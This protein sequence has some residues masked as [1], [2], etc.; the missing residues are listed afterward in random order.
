MFELSEHSVSVTFVCLCVCYILYWVLQLLVTDVSADLLCVFVRLFILYWVLQLLFTDI[1]ADLLCVFVRL[2][3]PI[4]SATVALHRRIRWFTAC[5]CAFVITYIE[6]YSCSSQTCP[7]IYCVCLCVCYILYWVL[8]LLFTD[9]SGD[10]LCVLMRLLYPILSVTVALH[11][12]IWW[13]TACV[14]A[15]VISY[16]ECYSCSSQ[17]YPVIYCVCLCVCYILYWVLQ[18]LFTDVSGDLL[19][20]FVRL[21]LPILSVTVALHRRIWWFTACVCAF[22]MSYIECYS[23]SSQTYPV[24][25]CVCLCVCYILYWVLQLLFTDVSGDLLRVFVR[26]LY[27]ILSVTVALHRRIRWFTACVC[28]FAISYIECYSCSLQ[29]YPVIYCV[30]APCVISYIECYSCSLQTYPLIYCVC[31]LYPI[32]SVTVAR[33]RRI[34]WFTACVCY[35]LYWVLQL[36]FTDVS[37]DLLCVFVRLLYPILS[38]QLLFTDVS[39]DLLCF[40]VMCYH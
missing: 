40:C 12:R 9:V 27:P 17:T 35:I 24:I 4:L 2:L 29:T 15:F 32:L 33:Y 3:Y 13:F 38:V 20:V 37:G 11:R 30:S 16:I 23:C 21:L 31:L 18:L 39:G 34:R 6:C 26:L 22:A 8:Q 10:L 14:C 7:L 5:V 1:S 25:Y 36:L 19:R 28:A